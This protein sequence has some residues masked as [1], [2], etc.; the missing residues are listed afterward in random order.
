MSVNGEL[1][2]ASSDDGVVRVPD[3]PL[4]RVQQSEKPCAEAFL[5]EFTDPDTGIVRHC[6]VA[7]LSPRLCLERA[8]ERLATADVDGRKWASLAADARSHPKER[9]ILPRWTRSSHAVTNRGVPTMADM[10]ELAMHIRRGGI[11]TLIGASAG[12]SEMASVALVS[13]LADPHCSL[14][15]PDL[16]YNEGLGSVSLVAID[17]ALS[18]NPASRLRS[19]HLGGLAPNSQRGMLRAPVRDDKSASLET[20]WLTCQVTR[21]QLVPGGCSAVGL[22]AGVLLHTPAGRRIEVIAFNNEEHIRLDDKT[23]NEDATAVCDLVSVAEAK[24][25][26]NMMR[27]VRHSQEGSLALVTINGK[28]TGLPTEYQVDEEGWP[29]TNGGWIKLFESESTMLMERANFL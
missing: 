19:L 28:W 2:E 4:A 9:L 1:N 23:T 29:V 7:G 11:R 15:V 3:D 26:I 16:K 10:L 25:L 6:T 8:L 24:M 13:A 27:N 5:R 18:A 20:Q 14:E 21:D 17:C 22:L 12:I